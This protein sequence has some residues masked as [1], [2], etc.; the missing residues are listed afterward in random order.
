MIWSVPCMKVIML[1]IFCLL[2]S[3]MAI[4]D[5]PSTSKFYDFSDQV[6]NG[7]IKKPTALYTDSRQKVRFGRLLKLK[8]SFLPKMLKSAKEPVFK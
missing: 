6:I 1:T 8:K 3:P 5:P 7:E 4:A 2:L